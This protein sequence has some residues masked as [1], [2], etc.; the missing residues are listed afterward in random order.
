VT[1]SYIDLAG[2]KPVAGVLCLGYNWYDRYHNN[3]CELGNNQWWAVADTVNLT[4]GDV[5]GYTALLEGGFGVDRATLELLSKEERWLRGV[6][7]GLQL[8]MSIVAGAELLHN[9]SPAGIRETGANAEQ[10]A[11]RMLERKGYSELQPLKNSSGHGID[12][13]GKNSPEEWRFFEVKGHAGQ[14]M[15]GLSAAQQ[16]ITRFVQT[17]VSRA[18]SGRGGYSPATTRLAESIRSEIAGTKIQGMVIN[19]QQANSWFPR[20]SITR[21]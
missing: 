20:V 11:I 17:R 21:W 3:V 19:V 8:G 16:D 13:V 10:S 12:I 1:H 2:G 5:L 9:L 6:T 14:G 18:A 4:L 15:P 7:G